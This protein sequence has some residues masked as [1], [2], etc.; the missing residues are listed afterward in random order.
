MN[1]LRSHMGCHAKIEKKP[2]QKVDSPPAYSVCKT[3]HTHFLVSQR[4]CS[5]VEKWFAGNSLSLF[6]NRAKFWSII[7]WIKFCWNNVIEIP[8]SSHVSC[9]E[10]LASYSSDTTSY[11]IFWTVYY[12]ITFWFIINGGD[13]LYN[14]GW[15]FG[16]C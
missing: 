16:A 11:L 1:K 12:F 4:V 6:Q 2:Q 10:P 15:T 3:R 13:P 5:N 14:L 8:V 7:K 9:S